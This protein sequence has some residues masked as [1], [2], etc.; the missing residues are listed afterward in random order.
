MIEVVTFSEAGRHGVN[1]D[2]FA[3]ESHPDDPGCFIVVLADG[4]SGAPGAA[5]A[6][7][8]ACHATVTR[9]LT[10]SP[11]RLRKPK[12]WFR[13]LH[14]SDSAV[15][16]SADA[17]ITTLIGACVWPSGIAGASSGDS[18]AFLVV[19]DGHHELTAEQ[20]KHPPVGSGTANLVPFMA[21]LPDSWQLYLLSDGVW[22]HAGRAQLIED[23]TTGSNSAALD[24]LQMSGRPP[25]GQFRDD[26][27]AV[28]LQRGMWARQASSA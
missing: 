5:E 24:A 21:P 15:H 9:A 16:A 13:I 10:L 1:Q 28:L 4:K 14:G 19:R 20:T 7:S 26:F 11:R 18:A 2:S 17:G 3:V 27:T 23:L 8:L 6:S 12:T 25:D 22:D